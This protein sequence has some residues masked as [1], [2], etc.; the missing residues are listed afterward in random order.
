MADSTID[1]LDT[2]ASVDRTADKL[3]IWDA[4]ASQTKGATINSTLG[5]SG[6]NPVS[7][8]DTQSL[9]NKTFDNTNTITV[10]DTLLTIQ[11]D[12]DTTKQVKFNATDVSTGTIRT[13]RFPNVSDILVTE[14]ATQGLTNKT[15]TSPTINTAT[16]NNPTLNTD[17]ISEYTAAAGV[18]VDGMLIKDGQIPASAIPNDAVTDARL[19]YGKVRSRQGGSATDWSSPGTTT[20]DYSGTNTFIQVG[21]ILNN[22]SPKA[23]TFP[24][25]FSQIPAVFVQ[26]QA[27][28]ANCFATVSS[29]TTT[30]FSCQVVTD[31]GAGSTAQNIFWWAI[32]E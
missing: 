15:L 13:F 31:A 14:S 32:G 3:A 24:N 26:P 9:T 25:A 28:T 10:K 21:C 6:G 20:Y 22:A 8:S 27:T 30:G 16:I 1:G 18:T 29:I 19:I 7:T 23:I 12:A 11:D 4:S 2:L 17:S 5:F